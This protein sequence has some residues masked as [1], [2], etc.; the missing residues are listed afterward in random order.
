MGDV[1][2]DPE[3]WISELER[4]RNELKRIHNVPV[5]DLDLMIHVMINLPREYHTL[6]KSFER[7]IASMSNKLST[8]I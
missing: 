5:S 1:E 7:K 8:E 4:M 6:I 3:E 2:Q